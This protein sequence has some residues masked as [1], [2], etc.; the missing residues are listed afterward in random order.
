MSTTPETTISTFNTLKVNDL[1]VCTPWETKCTKKGFQYQR[2][3]EKFGC[4]PITPELITRFEQV[5]GQPAHPWL[6]RGIFFAHRELGLIL[7][8]YEQ[9]KPIFLYT[10]RG[11]TTESLHLGHM[12]PFVFTK[13]LQDVFGAYLVIQIADDEKFHFKDLEFDYVYNLGFE[14]AKDIIAC[15][16]DPKK[17]L[18]FSNRDYLE[19]KAYIRL[20]NT[21][22]K[23]VNMQD[24]KSIFGLDERS[25]MG[26][27]VWPIYQSAAAFS[28]AF[29][30]IFGQENIR[31]L[32]A[33]AIDQDPYFRLCRDV[34]PKLGLLKPCSIMSQFLPA[35]EGES[36][37]S[38]SVSTVG[39]TLIPTIFMTDDPKTIQK[40]IN[41]FAFS[42]GRDTIEEHRRLGADLDIDISY[43][44]LK[45]FELDD[46]K[47]ESI[48]KLYGSGV[49]LSGEIKK[50][51]GNTISE[52]V[53]RH[54]TNR[55]LVTKNVVN[56]FY[57]MDKSD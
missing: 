32:V 39:R 45:Y 8:D 1:D 19:N 26:Q 35:L 54:Q 42:G 14:N 53:L 18:I 33:Y 30:D 36:K 52:F 40:K 13:W 29:T 41:K 47:L 10:G 55:A 7:D 3:I 56:K 2:I 16:F 57:S 50:I 37:M 46:A 25:N 11:P 44:Y 51:L 4:Q 21:M 28:A 17:T 20:I 15:G 24:I 34:G 48:G 31:C 38:S 43:Q 49:M 22:F 5:T 23:H 27:L 6:K 9:G 12:V